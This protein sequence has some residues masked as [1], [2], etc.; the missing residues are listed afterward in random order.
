MDLAIDQVIEVVGEGVYYTDWAGHGRDFGEQIARENARR[1]IDI[2][3]NKWRERAKEQAQREHQERLHQQ[4]RKETKVLISRQLQQQV[5][6]R[7]QQALPTVTAV[8]ARFLAEVY[9]QTLR[10]MAEQSGGR[11][12]CDQQISE[13]LREC[14]IVLPN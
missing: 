3:R 12:I 9:V 11:V 1:K 10:D 7:L 4:P 13:D 5:K 14:T 8:I 6:E 2:E